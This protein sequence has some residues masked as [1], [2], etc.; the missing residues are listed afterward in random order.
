[1]LDQR[2]GHSGGG[3]TLGVYGLAS[4]RHN[5]LLALI[6]PRTQNY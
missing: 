2:L 1:V 4:V 3:C 5:A 6:M